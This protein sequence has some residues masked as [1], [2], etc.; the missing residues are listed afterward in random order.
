LDFHTIE[1][2]QREVAD[3][4]KTRL[5]YRL[6]GPRQTKNIGI[7]VPAA[8]IKPTKLPPRG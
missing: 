7:E 5:R 4:L 3:P 1:E 6:Q 8:S 2:Y